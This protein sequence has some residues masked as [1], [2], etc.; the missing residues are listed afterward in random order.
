MPA[1]AGLCLFAAERVCLPP[2]A[3]SATFHWVEKV[4]YPGRR[5]G[6]EM[7]H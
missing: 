6:R 5:I 7:D 4:A 1:K 2:I 3:C